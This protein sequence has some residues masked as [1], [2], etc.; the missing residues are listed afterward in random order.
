MDQ[1]RLSV[2]DLPPFRP[3][4]PWWGGDLQ[5]LSSYFRRRA[6]LDAY[7]HERLVLPLNDGSGDR[8][9]ATL[10]NPAAA[11]GRPLAVL[12]HGLGGDEN[13]FYMC[14]SAAHLLALGYPVLRLNLRGAGPSRPFCRFQYHGGRSGD[15]AAALAALPAE[16]TAAGVIA[17]GYSLGGNM[18]LKFLG[19]RG[20]A[21]PLLAAVSV[22]APLDLAATSRR[23]LLR[24]NGF[25]S[26]YLM[27]EMRI[28]AAAPNSELTA[29]ERARLARVRTIWEFDEIFTAPRNGFADAT[30]YYERNSSRHFLA[31][32]GVPTLV[33][34]ALDDPWVPA[35][36]YRAATWGANPHLVPLL[37]PRGGHIGFFGGDGAAWYDR[38]AQRFLDAA[39]N[40]P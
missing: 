29:T 33:I 23:M 38:V 36:P 20:A 24:R 17:I 3:R 26:A 6:R 7:A 8:V 34:Y 40:R 11:T 14:N 39:L 16:V 4:A 37:S 28:E 21:A 12:I 13:S 1:A 22:S 25:Y 18:L 2:A 5:T 27:R 19:E 32:I 10:T 31:A 15:F 30:D 35:E 9:V